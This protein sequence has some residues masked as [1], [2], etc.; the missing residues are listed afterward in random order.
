MLE[1]TEIVVDCVV[2][3][4]LHGLLGLPVDGIQALQSATDGVANISN[5]GNPTMNN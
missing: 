2:G 4:H 5:A 3:C 1:A